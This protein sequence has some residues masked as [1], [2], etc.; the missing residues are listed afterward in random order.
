MSSTQVT[1]T[2]K[3]STKGTHVYEDVDDDAPIPTLYIKRGS[4]P[5]DPPNILIITVETVKQ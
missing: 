2:F 1:L 3:K 5:S 4:L